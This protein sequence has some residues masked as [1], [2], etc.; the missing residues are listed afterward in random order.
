MSQIQ[1][2]AQSA[3]GQLLF[4]DFN[5]ND[6]AASN[7]N[8]NGQLLKQKSQQEKEQSFYFLQQQQQQQQQI[9][10][11]YDDGMVSIPYLSS[12]QA[13]KQNSILYFFSHLQL[14]TMNETKDNVNIQIVISGEQTIQ[15]LGK[16]GK[17]HTYR[18]TNIHVP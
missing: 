8:D 10:L 3:F 2:Q 15:D 17:C 16:E 13:S 9:W 18:C 4:S 12:W 11:K 7:S 6:G 14:Y 5:D 1:K